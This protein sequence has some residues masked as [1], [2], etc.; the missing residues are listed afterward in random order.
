MA[1]KEVY[2]HKFPII[3]YFDLPPQ[4]AANKRW[5]YTGVLLYHQF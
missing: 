2:E 3:Q 5:R 1:P 4:I